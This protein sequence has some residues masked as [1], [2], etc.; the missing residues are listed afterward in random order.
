MKRIGIVEKCRQGSVYRTGS[1][2]NG[3]VYRSVGVILV[4]GGVLYLFMATRIN[5]GVNVGD[6]VVLQPV[7]TDETPKNL[8]PFQ[9]HQLRVAP[10]NAASVT[11]AID[12]NINKILPKQPTMDIDHQ[13]QVNNV[14][15]TEPTNEQISKNISININKIITL[16]RD[17]PSV[18]KPI[19]PNS[20]KDVIK[21][22]V[23][24][25]S[26][27]KIVLIIAYMRTGSTL[28]ASLFQE[29]PGTFY[30][31]EP[32]RGLTGK[33]K[34]LLKNNQTYTT[35]HYIHGKERNYTVSQKYEV[36]LD[37]INSWLT[38]KLGSISKESLN[39]DFHRYYTKIMKIFYFCSKGPMARFKDA[40]T[41]RMH[42]RIHPRLRQYFD[43]S[44]SIDTCLK[45][46]IGS[47]EKSPQRV[48]KLIRLPMEEAAKLLPFYPNMKIIHLL[49]DP[50]GILNSRI[51]VKAITP[52]IYKKNVQ[53]LCSRFEDDLKHSKRILQ[54][55]SDRLKIVHYEDMA[56]NPM[57]TAHSLV[58]FAGLEF[59]KPMQDFIRKQTSSLRDSCAY[60]TQRKNSSTTAHKWR[61][62]L[63]PK[64]AR[65]IYDT[66]KKS[67]S[68][69]GYLPLPSIDAMRDEGVPSRQI[70]DV[71]KELLINEN[72]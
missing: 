52:S 28:T 48:L 20:S 56:E 6:V 53:E 70:V 11:R 26:D 21:K 15:E 49:R 17:Q 38:C 71:N 61:T 19:S 39:D 68:V 4:L 60:C 25:L 65:Y 7:P 35:M 36:I 31:F 67:N 58:E 1:M 51:K 46:A 12:V 32:I 33:F 42:A 29:F 2:F 9:I 18:V 14:T 40:K 72:F 50:R 8:T 27:R 41:F 66:C 24:V 62:Q 22:N 37:E 59:L 55:Y 13:D 44:K 34:E 45:A 64:Y 47:C 54:Q 5:N 30:V 57:V 69:L 63:D 16:T 43:R 10:D 23:T 3:K